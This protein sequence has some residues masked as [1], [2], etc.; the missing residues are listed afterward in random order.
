LQ[1]ARL[2]GVDLSSATITHIYVAHAWFDRTRLQPEQLGGKIGE[3]LDAEDKSKSASERAQL[4]REAKYGYLA[5]KQNFDDLGDYNAASWAYRKERRMRKR[6]AWPR[7]LR[8][9]GDKRWWEGFQNLILGYGLSGH[10]YPTAGGLA[11]RGAA[12]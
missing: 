9:L 2:Q 12:S 3:Q 8:E 10:Q 6:E 11:Q 4:Y 5:L 1:N 7:G